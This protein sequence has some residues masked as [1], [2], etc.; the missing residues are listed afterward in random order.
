MSRRKLVLLSGGIDSTIATYKEVQDGN[1]VEA[2][3]LKTT[4]NKDNT[5]EIESAVRTASRLSIKHTVLDLSVLGA[6]FQNKQ[7]VLA[8]GGQIGRCCPGTQR[9]VNLGVETMHMLAMM[10]AIEHSIPIV[11][12]S[13]HKDDLREDTEESVLNYLR[14]MESIAKSRSGASCKFET[15]FLKLHKYEVIRLGLNLRVL[16][17]DTFSCFASAEEPCGVCDQCLAVKEAFNLAT[18]GSS[19]GILGAQSGVTLGA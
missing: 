9:G 8:V 16:L 17:R 2:L 11:T 15:P 12:W 10:Y 18:A 4:S 3:T 6:L 19:P 13:I 1:K 14:V 7:T 5:K